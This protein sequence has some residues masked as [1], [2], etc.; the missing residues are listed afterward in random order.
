VSEVA[1]VAGAYKSLVEL[2]RQSLIDRDPLRFGGLAEEHVVQA[3]QADEF[4]HRAL[5]IVYTEVDEDVGQ[6]AVAA[7]PLDHE[8]HG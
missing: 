5:V 1:T 4:V 8:Q 7:T 3:V 6:A 2:C